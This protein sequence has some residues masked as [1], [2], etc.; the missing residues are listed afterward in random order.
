MAENKIAANEEEEFEMAKQEAAEQDEV[1]YVHIFK[2]PFEWEGKTY[3]ELHF[4]FSNLTGEDCLNVEAEVAR[5]GTM[6]MVPVASGA[7]LIGI[8]ARACVEPLGTD[9]F[10][11][12]PINDFLTIRTRARNFLMYSEQ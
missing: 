4:D 3:K 8:S 2:K 5:R 10:R 9:A 11:R 12:M 1:D 6:I 7:F